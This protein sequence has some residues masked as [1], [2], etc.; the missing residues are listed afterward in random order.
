MNYRLTAVL[1]L[2][3]LVVVFVT[4]NAAVVE[5]RFLFWALD[6]SRAVVIFLAL[7]VGVVA[8]WILR[9]AAAHPRKRVR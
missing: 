5:I 7:A 6:V 2:L 3:G 4:Q 1:V 9:S 8:G